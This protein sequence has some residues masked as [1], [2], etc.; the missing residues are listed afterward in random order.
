MG[1]FKWTED[2]PVDEA[3]GEAIGAGS[4]CWN[5]PPMGAFDSE[6]ATEIV[7]ELMGFLRRKQIGL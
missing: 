5:P 4:M 2:T 7:E 1:M 3:V 6:R